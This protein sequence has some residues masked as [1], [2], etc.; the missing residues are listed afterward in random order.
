M[1][2]KFIPKGEGDKKAISVRIEQKAIAKIDRL[3]NINNVSRNEMIKQLLDFALE[4][5]EEITE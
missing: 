4:R 5:T 3:A 1:K 2:D